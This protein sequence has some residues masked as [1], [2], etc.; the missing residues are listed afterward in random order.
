MQCGRS[1]NIFLVISVPPEK[2]Q[3]YSFGGVSLSVLPQRLLVCDGSVFNYKSLLS[4]FVQKRTEKETHHFF[5][6][7]TEVLGSYLATF[8]F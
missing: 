8:F 1:D 5:L 2:Y 6:W 7:T 4:S 3:K